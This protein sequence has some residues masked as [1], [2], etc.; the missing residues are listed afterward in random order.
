VIARKQAQPTEPASLGHSGIRLTSRGSAGK[1]R[2]VFAGKQRNSCITSVR[3]NEFYCEDCLL[4]RGAEKVVDVDQK[5]YTLTD[6][7][8]SFKKDGKK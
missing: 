4:C 5:G 7:E 2:L 1:I 3:R 6:R 8:P